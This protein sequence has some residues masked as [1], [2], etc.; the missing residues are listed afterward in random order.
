MWSAGLYGPISLLYRQVSENSRMTNENRSLSGRKEDGEFEWSALKSLAPYLWTRGGAEAKLRVIAALF[1]LAAAKV[2]TVYIPIVYGQI[3]DTFGVGANE[4]IVLPVALIIAF[5]GLRVLSIAFGELR[6]A[7][8]TKVAQRA[9]RDVALKTFRHLHSLALRY[10]LERQTGGL[11]HAI[12][13]G[14]KA[15][16]FLLRFML[17]NILPTL[18]PTSILDSIVTRFGP[19]NGSHNR[20]F[21]SNFALV[22]LPRTSKGHEIFTFFRKQPF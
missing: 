20:S 19:P 12:E 13:R 8:F 4:G 2:A 11:S 16:D 6:D 7:V 5:G 18:I 1:L 17:F 14:T 21:S 22:E 10:H 3:V 9:I 15:I